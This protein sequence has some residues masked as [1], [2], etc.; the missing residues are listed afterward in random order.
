M[1]IRF[2]EGTEH[3][4]GYA[5]RTLTHAEHNY[6]QI[7]KEALAIIY[8]VKSFHQYLYGRKLVICSDHKPLIYLFLGAP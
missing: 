8:G 5:S 1:C 3:P 4:I 6:A 2:Q 7:D